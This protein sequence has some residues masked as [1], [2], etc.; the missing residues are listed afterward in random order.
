MCKAPLRSLLLGLCFL[1]LL[2]YTHAL[3][4]HPLE[5]GL[6]SVPRNVTYVAVGDSITAGWG[7]SVVEGA[8][9][10]GY[11]SQLHR[12][13]LVR[14]SSRLH[15]LGV[16]GLT[17]G[18]FLFVMEHWPEMSRLL[19]QAGLITLS[20]GGN[21]IIWTEHQSPGD[22]EKMRESL[23]KYEV[24]IVTILHRI[25][26]LNP[27]AR[28]FVLEVYNPFPIKDE[29]HQA[30][31]AWITWVN[32]SIAIAANAYD[33]EVIPTASLFL[34]KEN[35]YV[36]L[37]NNDIH[38]NTAGHTLIAE[39]ISGR[40]LGRFVPLIVEEKMKPNLLINGE[41][42]PLVSELLIENDTV[43]VSVDQL[44]G[45]FAGS[46]PYLRYRVGDWSIRINGKRIRLPS[47]VL[48]KDGR[49]Y[50]PLRPLS[51][52]LGA[53]IYWIPSSRTINVVTPS[54]SARK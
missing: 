50:L 36:N 42:K 33:A 4:L 53:Q 37:A 16:P 14:G 29:R 7:S 20:I 19:Q 28:L 25:R 15:N 34:S 18:Q 32:E 43:Y 1:L 27:Q 22:V 3:A 54:T 40:L 17:S 10:N 49:P 51:E 9:H 6:R 31:Q 39:T 13:L 12:Q 38:P 41:Q 52:T 21:D 5:P 26:K 11:V 48:L 2:P 30:L 8:R 45:L 23:S 35:Q 46:T 47:P 24:N 44:S